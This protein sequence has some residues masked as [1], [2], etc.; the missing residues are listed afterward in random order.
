M[1]NETESTITARRV[2]KALIE[3][4]GGP[5]PCWYAVLPYPRP[6]GRRVIGGYTTE[7]TARDA[8]E[9]LGYQVDLMKNHY[10][11]PSRYAAERELV[12]V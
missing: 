5:K 11:V 8:C 6:D 1:D 12:E 4:A 9:K 3:L 7:D 2:G 10:R